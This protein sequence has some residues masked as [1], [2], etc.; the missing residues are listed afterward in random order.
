MIN[1][2]SAMTSINDKRT[3]PFGGTPHRRLA[4]AES[5]AYKYSSVITHLNVEKH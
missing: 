1:M 3:P 5:I 2:K 4:H